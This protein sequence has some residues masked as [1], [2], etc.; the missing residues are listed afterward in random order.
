MKL[1]DLF[2]FNSVWNS[3]F[4]ALASA[5]AVAALLFL[6]L[7]VPQANSQDRLICQPLFDHV[8][9]SSE[10]MFVIETILSDDDLNEL[11]Q[12]GLL[13]PDKPDEITSSIVWSRQVDSQTTY[14]MSYVN[15]SESCYYGYNVLTETR[16]NSIM[17]YMNESL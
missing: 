2:N 6:V 8:T 3:A 11:I 1:K 16:Y 14:T 12:A 17:D 9:G 4:T 5:A 13:P 15:L 7:P 10:A